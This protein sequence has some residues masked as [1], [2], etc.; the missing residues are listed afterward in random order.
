MHLG[1]IPLKQGYYLL[2]YN[3][4][5][6]EYFLRGRYG[7][8]EKKEATLAISEFFCSFVWQSGSSESLTKHPS[9]CCRK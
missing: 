4:L 2:I 9:S 7:K 5:R 3:A 6:Q 8:M 1:A